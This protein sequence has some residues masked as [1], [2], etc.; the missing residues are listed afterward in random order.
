MA[1]KKITVKLNSHKLSV[2]NMRLKLF[3]AQNDE[4]VWFCEDARMQVDFSP[5]KG[6]TPFASPILNIPRNDN[7]AH[8]AIN[9]V[10]IVPY[11]LTIFHPDYTVTIDPEVDADGGPPGSGNAAVKKAAKKKAGK[12]NAGKKRKK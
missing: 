9:P 6:P 11:T 8:R 2:D 3:T 4:V 1:K 5:P 10:N 7:T 12:K